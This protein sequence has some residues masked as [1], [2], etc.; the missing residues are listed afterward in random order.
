M[1]TVL[2]RGPSPSAQNVQ[3]HVGAVGEKVDQGRYSVLADQP[4]GESPEHGRLN[5]RNGT[6]GKDGPAGEGGESI[7]GA[8]PRSKGA[9]A[10]PGA[11]ASPVRFR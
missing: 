8:M 9:R 10:A 4:F 1:S 7:A 6:E 5:Y 11:F 2:P 3:H